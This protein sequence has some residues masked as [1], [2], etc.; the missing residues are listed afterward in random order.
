MLSFLTLI[1]ILVAPIFTFGCVLIYF[2]HPILGII[3][4]VVSIIRAIGD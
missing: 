1:G 2:D 3:A 4:I